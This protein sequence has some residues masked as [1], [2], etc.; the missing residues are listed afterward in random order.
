MLAAAF[1]DAQGS[2][3][4]IRIWDLNSRQPQPI[5]LRNPG[6]TSAPALSVTFSPHAPILAAAEGSSAQLLTLAR[7][8]RSPCPSLTVGTTSNT[9]FSIA[10]SPDGRHLVSG[11]SDHTIQLWNLTP[12]GRTPPA[13]PSLT[14][15]DVTSVQSVAF[16]PTGN[17][18]ADGDAFGTIY[19]WNLNA[20]YAI[21]RICAEEPRLSRK[22]WNEY[23][24]EL[25]Y[26]PTC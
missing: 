12:T 7:P 1:A 13:E 10:F 5:P 11:N 25:P 6:Q 2:G 8:S 20:R 16:S 22:E 18:F 17:I 21:N 26:N 19:L 9:I 24:P 15:G 14:L 4:S 3:G 23:T